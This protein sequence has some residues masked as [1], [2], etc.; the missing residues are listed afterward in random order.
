LN[1]SGGGMSA[2]CAATAK[3]HAKAS[4]LLPSIAARARRAREKARLKAL[5]GVIGPGRIMATSVHVAPSVT[6]AEVHPERASGASE[7]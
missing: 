2:A 7:G 5:L 6:T 3:A 1:A 4:A